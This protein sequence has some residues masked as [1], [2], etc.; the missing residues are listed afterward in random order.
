MI[1]VEGM[2]GGAAMAEMRIRRTYGLA[3]ACVVPSEVAHNNL[4]NKQYEL[5]LCGS[6]TGYGIL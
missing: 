2:L 6:P 3:N 4:K 1:V 5:R